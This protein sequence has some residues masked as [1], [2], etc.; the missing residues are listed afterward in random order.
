M[1]PTDKHK[2]FKGMPLAQ[3]KNS[4]ENIHP[5]GNKC[6]TE[7]E[8]LISLIPQGIINSKR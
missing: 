2:I 8:P 6:W 4:I 1:Q 5:L 7:I 3:L